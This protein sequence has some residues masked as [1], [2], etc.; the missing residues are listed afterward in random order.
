MK[1]NLG[2]FPAGAAAV[3]FSY[4]AGVRLPGLQDQ[5][6]FIDQ[7]FFVKALA[8]KIPGQVYQTKDGK[9][10]KVFDALEW[11]AAMSSYVTNKGEQTVH[12]YGYISNVSRGKRKQNNQ[13]ELIS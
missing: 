3:A 4:I 9:I 10:E 12:Y 8:N 1:K 13:D 5:F 11:L 7:M 6:V 2:G